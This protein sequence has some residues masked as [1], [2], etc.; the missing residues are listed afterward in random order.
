MDV[1]SMRAGSCFF[2]G[3]GAFIKLKLPLRRIKE[4]LR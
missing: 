2:L 3:G 1:F 4:S